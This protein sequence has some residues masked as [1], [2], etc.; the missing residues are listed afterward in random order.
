M[1]SFVEIT[2]NK[3]F[4]FGFNVIVM[5]WL[6]GFMFGAVINLIKRSL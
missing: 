6:F 3:M 5:F 2:G 1:F 4:D